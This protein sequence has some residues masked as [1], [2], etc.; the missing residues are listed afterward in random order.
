M[1]L[2]SNLY[3]RKLRLGRPL[4][5][6]HNCTFASI[7]STSSA[8]CNIIILLYDPILEFS[9]CGLKAQCNP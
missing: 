9:K 7:A 8:H 1:G 4:A 3:L 5:H 6:L 2:K